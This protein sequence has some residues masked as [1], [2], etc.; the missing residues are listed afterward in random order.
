MDTAGRRAHVRREV[1]LSYYKV[2]YASE[3]LWEKVT[4][5]PATSICPDEETRLRGEV[6]GLRSQAHS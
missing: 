2:S 5:G 6:S 3:L 4:E 1:E